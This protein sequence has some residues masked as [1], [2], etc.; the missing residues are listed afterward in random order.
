MTEWWERKGLEY[1]EGILLA[2]GVDTNELARKYGTPLYVSDADRCLENFRRIKNAFA[3][4][5]DRH[6]YISVAEKAGFYLALLEL[7]HEL[8]SFSK[9]GKNGCKYADVASP[10]EARISIEAGF[11]PYD[12]MFTGTSVSNKTLE[13][14]IELGVFINIDSLSQLRRLNEIDREKKVKELSI[15]WNPGIG[16]GAF[17]NIITAGKEV[18]GKPIKFGIE[19]GKMIY[20][21]QLAMGYDRQ[22]VGLHQHIGS[23]WKGKDIE[24]FMKTVDLTLKMADKMIRLGCPIRFVGFGG[25][26]GIPYK[27]D[28]EEFPIEEYARGICEKV[29]NSGLD[30][31]AIEIEPGRY[32]VG[33]AGI[34]LTEVNTVEEKNGNLLLGTDAGFH[35]LIRP[36]FYDS[37]HEAV[38]CKRTGNFEK[39]SIVGPLCETSDITTRDEVDGEKQYKRNLEIPREGDIIAILNAGAYGYE[40][41][42]NYNGWLKAV[43]V[44]LFNGKDYLVTR[45]ETYEDIRGK[46]KSISQDN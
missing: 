12:V 10:T 1:K 36:A 34:L 19:E 27:R 2:N 6:L 23:N 28:E 32:I 3:K 8:E 29:K 42:S 4:Y 38:L 43:R 22:V 30:F 37:H 26:P 15:R 20:A 17:D 46:E 14:L 40:M 45:R 11:Q 24:T 25:G 9:N 16:A 21:C 35:T 33:D 5:I 39:A 18:H 44:M 31:K 13:E 41:G 7:L